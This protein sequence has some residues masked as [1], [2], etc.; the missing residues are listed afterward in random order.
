MSVSSP[1]ISVSVII[2]TFNAQ[3]HI[4]ATLA[5]LGGSNLKKE[6]LVVD[7]GSSDNTVSLA[8]SAGA[9]VVT[10]AKGRGVQLGVG[11]DN[12]KG[13]AFLFL[14]GDTVLRPGWDAAVTAFLA[15]QAYKSC[16]AYFRFALDDDAPA[17][18]RLAGMVAWRCR[19][20]GLPYG[21]QGLLIGR[22]FYEA[23]GGYAPLP[24]MED[25]EMVRRIGKRHLVPLDVAAV[26]SSSRYRRSGYL[27]RSLRN[28][29]SL[30]LYFM[31][32]PIG[33][34]VRVYE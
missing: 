25:V 29:F 11:A 28:L 5:A 24:L 30:F 31:G 4:G 3:E 21:D 19:H 10:S 15:D 32:V 34:I 17:A 2:V 23:L 8:A 16:A 9:R 1:A 22:Q 7:G 12:A 33:F 18:R 27:G 13:D 6:I 26:T 20:L 14:H